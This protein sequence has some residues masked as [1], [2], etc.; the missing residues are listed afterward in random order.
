MEFIYPSSGAS[1]SF[2]PQ[3]SGETPGAVFRLAHRNASTTIWWHLDGSYVGETTLI[4]E[5]RL[6]PEAGPHILT[7]IDE[8]GNSLSVRFSVR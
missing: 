4:H 1:L 2:P 7:V 5:L 8:D 6:A 3:L